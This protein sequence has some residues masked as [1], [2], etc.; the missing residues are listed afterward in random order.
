VQTSVGFVFE[1]HGV[2]VELK[3]NLI[4][5]LD[6]M[7]DRLP[8]ASKFVDSKDAA[9]SF[10]ILTAG[11]DGKPKE[12]PGHDLYS[13]EIMLMHAVSLDLALTALESI[14][15]ATVAEESPLLFVHAG[16][17]GWQGGAIVIPGR[18]MS[19]KSTLVAALISAGATY[20]SDEYALFDQDGY[21]HAYP[22]PLSLR[23]PPGRVTK[24]LVEEI[25][26]HSL[27]VALVVAMWYD[28]DARWQPQNLTPGQAVL[29][30]F[31]NTIDAR[32]RPQCAINTLARAV[33]RGLAIRGPRPSADRIVP[34][35]LALCS[36]ANYRLARHLESKDLAL[37]VPT[38]YENYD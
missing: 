13:G 12:K 28:A 15:H 7:R 34:S 1:S 27:P 3:T 32:R 26:T 17:V 33:T 20:Y 37:A 19:G 21:V 9:C 35:I 5:I 24:L 36:D 14:L 31:E 18:S 11:A 22:R 4:S 25:G 16:V 23:E 8:P 38:R 29:R 2:R 30:L 6:A 10:N